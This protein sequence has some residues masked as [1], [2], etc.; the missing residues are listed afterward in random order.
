MD[1]VGLIR[2]P[3]NN[4]PQEGN[5]PALFL[6]SNTEIPDFVILQIRQLMVVGGKQ[7]LGM[8]L[9][10]DVL[11]HRPGNAHAVKGAGSPAYLIQNHQAV[12]GG[13]LQ[14][15]RHLVHL[16]HK[17]ALAADQI[18]TGTDTGK[19]P[20]H[21]RNHRLPCGDKAANL[22]HQ[23]QQRRLPHIGGLACHIWPGDQHNLAVIMVQPGVVRHKQIPLKNPLHQRMPA[24][25]DVELSV[26]GQPW[27]HIVVA[28]CRLRQPRQHIQP[29]NLPGRSLNIPQLFLDGI[30]DF[31]KE[32]I[33]NR[34]NLLLGSQ[35]F[36][37][38]LLQFL[39]DIPL[40]IGKSLLADIMRRHLVRT[41]VAHLDIVAENLV[42][43]DFQEADAGL[44]LLLL[45]HLLQKL[46]AVTGNQPVLV[47]FLVV[48]VTD[49]PPV[50]EGQ[51]R[52]IH[53]STLQQVHKIL[54]EM[55]ALPALLQK[56]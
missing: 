32:V 1:A 54:I 55:D 5:I 10:P 48:T 35:D 39:C 13:I 12:T 29:G 56:P 24:I 45:L 3:G 38:K 19:N 9:F 15:L 51:P 11:Y 16:H 28:G 44:F 43:A 14:N 40:C 23:H 21:R 52:L 2:R 49:N 33:L 20:V 31:H 25:L 47:Q 8:H 26:I 6:D 22:R 17:G 41:A 42:V 7:G 4:P 30:P 37:L 36:R 27:P 46:P 53:D 34:N 18:I 50:T